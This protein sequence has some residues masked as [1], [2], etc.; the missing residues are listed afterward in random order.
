GAHTYLG[1]NRMA[2]E[3]ALAAL[4]NMEHYRAAARD[5]ALERVRIAAAARALSGAICYPSDANFVLLRLPAD[6]AITLESRLA[7]RG[8]VIKRCV[9]P[10]LAG[11]VRVSV[12]TAHQTDVIIDALETLATEDR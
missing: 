4:D 12:G 10:L 1:H 11:C 2:E 7:Q 5:I 6:G 3:V 8:V 9:E